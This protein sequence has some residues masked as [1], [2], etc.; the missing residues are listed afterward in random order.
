M[1]SLLVTLPTYL[2]KIGIKHSLKLK[3]TTP[4]KH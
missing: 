1:T 3:A 2:K 4:K